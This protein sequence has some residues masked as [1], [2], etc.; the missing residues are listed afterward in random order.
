MPT[1]NKS[2]DYGYLNVIINNDTD[3]FINAEYNQQQN[4]PILTEMNDWQTSVVRFKIPTAA[5]PLFIFED[6]SYYIGFSIGDLYIH[7]EVKEIQYKNSALYKAIGNPQNRYIFYYNHFI[8]LVN[9]AL[10]EL[11]NDISILAPY[12]PIITP[13]LLLSNHAPY[14]ALDAN[15]EY[16][17]LHLPV[18]NQIPGP[19]VEWYSPFSKIN[20]LQQFINLHMNN[21]LFY[22]FSGFNASF[23]P[24]GLD[25]DIRIN[26]TFDVI[27]YL[28][29]NTIITKDYFAPNQT[30]QANYNIIRQDY[31]S[32]FLWQTL[33]R[34]LITTTVPMDKE[35]ILTRNNDGQQVKQEIFTD[36]E[37]PPTQ[38]GLREYIFFF[39][40]GD[41]RYSNFKSTGWLDRFDIRIYYQTKDLTIYPVLIPPTFEISLKIEF[42]RR[43]SKNLLQHSTDTQ[44]KII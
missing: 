36:Y 41:V 23:S 27:N 32:L 29:S 20:I 33:T 13:N 6:D 35:A 22:F 43:K 4:E 38:K 10:V 15:S 28:N 11:W 7:S 2:S 17:L 19:A 25:N 30:T 26:Y 42:K 16:L 24:N 5:V 44:R 34:I 9:D 37:I 40:Q 31:A 14:F 21:K 39:P 18:I 1:L 3:N 8:S 12:I